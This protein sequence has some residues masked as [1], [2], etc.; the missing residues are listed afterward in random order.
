[1]YPLIRSILTQTP[2]FSND[3]LKIPSLYLIVD[4]DLTL[5]H[6]GNNS[7]FGDCIY[8]LETILVYHVDSRKMAV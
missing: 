1:M 6:A 3:F 2:S 7:L 4:L 8:K 5:I